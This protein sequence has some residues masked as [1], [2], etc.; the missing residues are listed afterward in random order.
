M[1]ANKNR[2]AVPILLVLLIFTAPVTISN[3]EECTECHE[4]RHGTMGDNCENCHSNTTFSDGK[5]I[6]K[7]FSP[8]FIHDSFDW[9]GDNAD[10]KEPYRLEESC[11]VCHV[12]MLEHSSQT[13]NI[14]EDC[15]VK[16]NIKKSKLIFLRED[17]DL[18]V[19]M[20]Y[21]H[22]NG[23][24]IDVPDQSTLGG[25]KSTCFGFNEETG[26]GSCHGVDFVNRD[27]TGGFFAFNAE[28]YTAGIINRG[29]PY[30]WNGPVDFMPDTKDC[31][32]CHI[33]EDSFMRKAWGD[34]SPLPVDK[35]HQNKKN[36][37]CWDCHVNGEFRSFHGKEIERKVER[38]NF[39]NI[40]IIISLALI[41][42]FI[43]KIRL[44][45]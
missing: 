37:D 17:I 21:S 6:E 45:K 15:H 38:Q 42:I 9:E 5:H 28:N 8:G 10:E 40:F 4:V 33:Q 41:I 34:P 25:T 22:F 23:S 24:S 12:S 31:V 32:F 20:I 7:P 1:V 27:R 3:A 44:K 29:D 14:C 18:Y 13:L 35:S 30:H 43:Y 19:P 39:Q 11:P 26:E 2:K 16:D 36:E